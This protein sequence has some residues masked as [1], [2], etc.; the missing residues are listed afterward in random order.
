MSDPKIEHRIGVKAP[1]MVVWDLLK[2]I[3][4]WPGWNPLYPKARGQL[5]YGAELHLTQALPDQAPTEIVATVTEWVPDEQILW[6]TKP[7]W[8]LR[9]TRYIEI[10]KLT[11]TACIFANGE[12]LQGWGAHAAGR[13]LGRS[14]Y[15]G[16]ELMGE[17]VK[18]RAEAMW[19]ERNGATP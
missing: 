9:T 12:L 2:D 6:T 17:A 8:Q 13:R 16:F 14:M 11:D 3:E 7:S 19:L 18:E 1:P 4:A 15:K 5:G 10:D